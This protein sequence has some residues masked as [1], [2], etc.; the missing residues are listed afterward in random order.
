MITYHTYTKGKTNYHI[1]DKLRKSDTI[2]FGDVYVT[3]TGQEE[4]SHCPFGDCTKCYFT[5][6]C[7]HPDDHNKRLYE[8]LKLAPNLLTDYPE[9]GV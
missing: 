2:T 8:I 7:N 3:M 4:T 6:I 1:V 5:N 9:L